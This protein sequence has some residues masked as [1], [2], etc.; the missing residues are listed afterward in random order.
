[1]YEC[2]IR[3]LACRSCDVGGDA[4]SRYESFFKEGRC[5]SF[6]GVETRNGS[7]ALIKAMR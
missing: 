3:L 2:R 7:S 1:M 4:E 6:G 5:L